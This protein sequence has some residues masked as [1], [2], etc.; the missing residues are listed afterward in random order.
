MALR[1][2]R[3]SRVVA[4]SRLR[5]SRSQTRRPEGLPSTRRCACRRPRRSVRCAHD[6][7]HETAHDALK[8]KTA[9]N[10]R[11]SMTLG[12]GDITHKLNS[13]LRYETMKQSKIGKSITFYRM[14][15]CARNF[16]HS[17]HTCVI[18]HS[19]PR[20]ARRSHRHEGRRCKKVHTHWLHL[21]RRI[22]RHA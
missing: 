17:A 19:D 8:C 13:S 1:T 4:R 16:W 5:P 22:D 9:L 14:A 15:W 3:R 7:K 11:S 20:H 6:G 18:R 12:A 21:S 2:Y 10:Q